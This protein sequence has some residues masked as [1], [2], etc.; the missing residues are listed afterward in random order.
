M[1]VLAS[2]MLLHMG[3]MLYPL[4]QNK[5]I[6]MDST[7]LSPVKENSII[8]TKYRLPSSLCM[9]NNHGKELAVS[10]LKDDKN[11]QVSQKEW[12]LGFSPF[13]QP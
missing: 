4:K 5:N 11:S 9:Q 7:G 3:L 6:P 2:Y 13:H 1:L 12:G 10:C 8:S